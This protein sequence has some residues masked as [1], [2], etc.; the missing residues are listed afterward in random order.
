[1]ATKL[2]MTKT[3]NIILRTPLNSNPRDHSDTDIEVQKA[4]E[5]AETAET[6]EAEVAGAVEEAE[7]LFL[8]AVSLGPGTRRKLL[9]LPMLC[10][11]SLKGP[12]TT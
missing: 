11:Y 2:N 12:L 8:R 10:I 3:E 6:A 7:T 9:K 4:A 5:M 1:M